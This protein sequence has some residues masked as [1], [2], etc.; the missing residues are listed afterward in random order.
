MAPADVGLGVLE[1][2]LFG[3]ALAQL[4]LV[5]ARL[6][7][8]HRLGAIAMLRAIVLALHDDVG[9]QMRDTHGRVGLVDVLAARPR[10]AKRVDANI[11]RI[12]LHLDGL[13]DLGIDENTGEGSMATGVCVERA[14]AHEAV[15]ARLGP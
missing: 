10:R 15:N 13:V 14:L 1:L 5:Q 7:H 2:L 9:R 12:D 8:G 3:L 4:Q 11:G 6:E